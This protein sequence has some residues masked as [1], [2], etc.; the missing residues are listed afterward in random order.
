MAVRSISRF[1]ASS[2]LV[3]LASVRKGLVLAT[4]GELLACGDLQHSAA[5]S[6]PVALCLTGPAAWGVLWSGETAAVGVEIAT[7]DIYVEVSGPSYIGPPPAG[8]LAV[9]DLGHFVA[10]NPAST[11]VVKGIAL[12]SGHVVRDFLGSAYWYPTWSIFGYRDGTLVL[13]EH[14]DITTPP[15]EDKPPA[16]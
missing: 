11:N 14:F 13:E 8:S 16:P 2:R 4:S 7:D 1:S 15:V 6:H 3:K 12:V 5:V 10:S 9:T